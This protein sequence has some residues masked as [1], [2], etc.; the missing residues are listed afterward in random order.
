LN[1]FAYRDPPDSQL[2]VE[3]PYSSA[4]PFVEEVQGSYADPNAILHSPKTV[5][6]AHGLEGIFNAAIDAG[7]IIRKFR[8]LD[9][10]PW[11]A[12][13]QLVKADDTYWTL[14]KGA[15]FIP[16]AFTLDAELDK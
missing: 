5:S 12:L 15:P 14:P 11:A 1:I 2:R 3:L 4:E 16:L 6:W 8:E 13:P 7:F 10:V 9:R